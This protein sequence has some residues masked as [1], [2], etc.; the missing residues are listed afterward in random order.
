MVKFSCLKPMWCMIQFSC[1]QAA[2]VYGSIPVSLSASVVHSAVCTSSELCVV[3]G[4]VLISGT[5]LAI[6]LIH[7]LAGPVGVSALD[8]L[9]WVA[10]GSVAIGLPSIALKGF[11]ALK[12]RVRFCRRPA[13]LCL[14]TIGLGGTFSSFTLA[15]LFFYDCLGRVLSRPMLRKRVRTIPGLLQR[16]WHSQGLH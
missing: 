13:V 10:L 5:L 14:C 9:R 16:Q 8:E 1:L 12:N 15:D 2:V 6:S 3:H 7:Y 11:I 4:A